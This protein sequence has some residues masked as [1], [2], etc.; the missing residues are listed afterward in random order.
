MANYVKPEPRPGEKDHGDALSMGLK[1]LPEPKRDEEGF[2]ALMRE[3]AVSAQ[4]W[5]DENFDLA[6]ENVDFAAGKHWRPSDKAARADEPTLTINTVAA[7][8]ETVCGEQRQNR[9]AIHVHPADDFGARQEYAV[10][11]GKR[12]RK[13]AGAELYEGII[14]AIEFQSGAEMHYD[15]AHRHA[16]DGGFGW[17][18][19]FTRYASGR[20][21]D[22]ELLIRRVKNRWS[23]LLDPSAQEPDFSDAGYG[24]IGEDMLRT[25]YDRRWP[26]KPI[27]ALVGDTERFFGGASQA[28]VRVA[29]YFTRE[30][31]ERELVLL[32]DGTIAWMDEIEPVLDELSRG[33]PQTDAAGN[34]VMDKDGMPV[35]RK[36]VEVVRSRKVSA[37]CV[38]WHKVTAN[39]VL[40]GPVE[41]P[42][43]SIPLVPVF[44]RE[45]NFRDGRT[46]YTALH[47]EAKEPARMADY[48]WSA[49]TARVGSAPK[50]P[51][52]AT[53]DAIEGH[54]AEWQA[55]NRGNP[56]VL[57]YNAGQEKPFRE[58]PP[59]MP[60]AET[61]MAL[62]MQGMVKD[63]LGLGAPGMT[64]V[65][66]DASGTAMRTRK[67]AEMTGTF[68][69][70]DNLSMALRRIGL[71]LVEAIPKV[72]DTER[73]M[74][75]RNEDG[76]GEWVKIN[77]VVKDEQTG[78]EVVVNGIGQGE[79]DVSVSAGPS[80]ATLRQETAERQIEALRL[81]PTLGEVAG[82]LI[83]KSQD[84]PE[85]SAI[86]D[87]KRR[88]IAATQP[89]LLS[90]AEQDELAEEAKR[91]P[92]VGPDGQPV[93]SPEEQAAAMQAQQ[94]QM[95]Q[96]VFEAETAAK[97]AK[98]QAD[99]AKAEAVKAQADADKLEAM[100]KMQALQ[101]G[102]LGALKAQPPSSAPG[103]TNITS[104]NG[105]GAQE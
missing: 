86:A 14:R 30:A 102:G 38:Y 57:I 51:W 96:K 39:A 97:M 94:Q 35:I 17:L 67:A 66:S 44:G 46:T 24:F 88:L 79:Y 70:T 47:N 45:R 36:P 95:A 85:A 75:L 13:V 100:L 25:E 10:G 27:G 42:F 3:R 81:D 20:D 83:Y 49:A 21:F 65:G 90:P 89:A 73:T 43:T 9:P 71:L 74:R 61:Q 33:G 6:E 52:V 77:H 78:Q 4:S 50:N 59:P 18:R 12:Q 91:E 7:Q 56:A 103:P 1:P 8:I 64:D 40:A 5:W 41:M 82:D 98:A 55:A 63:A 60:V 99:M 11:A 53:E 104:S 92:Q 2:L 101:A 16:V 93:P 26:D 68:A 34:P 80:Y 84:W 72:Y 37:W 69:F 58:P 28:M 22:Q 105:T 48:W 62:S 76:T 54:M 29:E 15:A 32:S 87:R 19:V 23:V 31:R